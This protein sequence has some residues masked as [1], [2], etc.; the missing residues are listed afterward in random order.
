MNQ[1]LVSERA[2]L[3][4]QSFV[5]ISTADLATNSKRPFTVS[6]RSGDSDFPSNG[7]RAV[8]AHVRPSRHRWPIEIIHE[9]PG[10]AK[11]DTRKNQYRYRN[12]RI[13]IENLPPKPPS[14]GRELER[15]RTTL[16]CFA[17]I[18][19]WHRMTVPVIDLHA[20]RRF[21]ASSRA[22]KLYHYDDPTM[23]CACS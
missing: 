5:R 21:S 16:K 13:H 6:A 18:L 11:G 4:L 9:E 15:L 23:R 8:A 7:Q 17:S 2:W 20:R 10:T 22:V 12:P 19:T 14:R 1:T 3:L